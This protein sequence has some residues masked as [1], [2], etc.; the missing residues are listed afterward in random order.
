M[1]RDARSKAK[2][3][4]ASSFL[5][6]KAELAKKEEEFA[7]NSASGK[8]PSKPEKKPTV[9][10]RKN[11]G[12][13]SRAARDIELE[14]ISKPT[15]DS[16][17]A[18]LERKAKIYDKL[19][20]GKSGGLS[21][22]QFDTLLVDFDLKPPE[23]E[24]DEDDI[25]ESLTVPHAPDDVNDPIIEYEDEFGRIRTARRSE[26]PRELL[27]GAPSEEVDEDEDIIIR[28]PVNHF[29]IYTPSA[30][31]IAEIEKMH[32]EENNPLGVHYDASSEVRAK[33]A[34][35]YQFSGDEET[36]QRQMEELRAAREKTQ[37]ARQGQ[38]A[39]DISV[40]GMV[41]SGGENG[42][43]GEGVGKGVEKRKRE[44]EERRR[45][46]EAKRRKLKGE[47][48]VADDSTILTTLLSKGD[49]ETAV[50]V[51]GAPEPERDMTSM[52]PDPFAVLESRQVTEKRWSR[53]K[54]KS[55]SDEADVFLAS[56]ENDILNRKKGK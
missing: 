33:G 32:A 11:K 48:A 14:A 3:I 34:G 47:P 35:F 9:W 37:Q 19:R 36:R 28:N 51:A 1:S 45:K 10:A 42:S 31:R 17:R 6:L 55:R 52:T 49:D 24:D 46:I 7:R 20:K 12:V 38:G 5:D 30:D 15:L 53:G 41:A 22:K 25:D 27:P 16:A 26:I 39:V 8:K 50:F 23:W 13:S 29:P 56:L 44:I 2:G 4:S 18:T 43:T 40:E 54:G 21:E